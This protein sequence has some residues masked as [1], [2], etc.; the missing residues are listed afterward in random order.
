MAEGPQPSA[1]Q[2][3]LV[4]R[5]GRAGALACYGEGAEALV[6]NRNLTSWT[7]REVVP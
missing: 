7:H 1:C 2:G 3:S 4:Q 6:R 5:G